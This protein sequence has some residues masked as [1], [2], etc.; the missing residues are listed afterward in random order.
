MS[1]QRLSHKATPIKSPLC[2]DF[3]ESLFTLLTLSWNFS[4]H[5]QVYLILLNSFLQIPAQ[6]LSPLKS[7]PCPLLNIL[8]LPRIPIAAFNQCSPH[9]IQPLYMDMYFWLRFSWFCYLQDTGRKG[10][11][12]S[13]WKNGTTTKKNRTPQNLFRTYEAQ[14]GRRFNFLESHYMLTVIH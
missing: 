10:T 1:S 9:P 3:L 5:I 4:S 11:R 2:T 6:V 14:D 7:L 12:H 8:N 13:H